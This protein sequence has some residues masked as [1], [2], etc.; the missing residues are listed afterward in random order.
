[1]QPWASALNVVCSIGDILLIVGTIFTWCRNPAGRV[2]AIGG[3]CLT[4]AAV[5]G[6]ELMAVSTPGDLVVRPWTRLSDVFA[7]LGLARAAAMRRGP[8]A[9]GSVHS[10]GQGT[11][12]AQRYG[13]GRSMTSAA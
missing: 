9:S 11:H 10:S 12:S 3:L 2:L 8:V 13:A 4:L 7:V 1:L 5:V 6:F